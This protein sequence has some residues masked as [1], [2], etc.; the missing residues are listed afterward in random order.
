MSECV[1]HVPTFHRPTCRPVGKLRHVGAVHGGGARKPRR[2]LSWRQAE[3]ETDFAA[4]ECLFDFQTFDFQTF[5]LF[6]AG[7]RV[8]RKGA[9]EDAGKDGGFG[10][11]GL[12][13]SWVL[14][15]WI[16]ASCKR[17]WG[18]SRRPAGNGSRRKPLRK[19]KHLCYGF[20]RMAWIVVK[21][22]PNLKRFSPSRHERAGFLQGPNA[23][24]RT[25]EN[26]MVS[27]ARGERI[28]KHTGLCP[29]DL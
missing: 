9:E 13:G 28:A 11:W 21:G 14:G 23:L 1:G 22:H 17:A 24:P 20:W 16:A 15:K 4:D 6:I 27:E 19:W 12:S 29:T 18:I 10:G 3:R 8:N 26:R 7:R 5:R 25:S 2:A